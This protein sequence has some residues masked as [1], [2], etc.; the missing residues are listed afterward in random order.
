MRLAIALLAAGCSRGWTQAVTVGPAFGD[1][2]S[3]VVAVEGAILLHEPI[4]PLPADGGALLS[5]EEH[6]P[7]SFSGIA[8][9]GA[10]GGFWGPGTGLNAFVGGSFDYLPFLYRSG[11]HVGF[12]GGAAA[13]AGE[14]GGPYLVAPRL[15]FALPFTE[16]GGAPLTVGG[17][18][19][20]QILLEE[21]DAGAEEEESFRG[22]CGPQLVFVRIDHRVPPP[23]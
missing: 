7:R 11:A 19:R 23:R 4:P 16:L 2:T 6:R 22:G 9:A 12:G 3:I 17:M 1:E 5:R 13:V 20:C 14:S 10:T 15:W 21:A 8:V 18:L